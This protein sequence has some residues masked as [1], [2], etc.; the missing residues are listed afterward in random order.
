MDWGSAERNLKHHGSAIPPL[1]DLGTINTKA[2]RRGSEDEPCSQIALF[3]GD[4]DWLVAEED[5][6]RILEQ[7]LGIITSF[8]PSSSLPLPSLLSARP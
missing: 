6:E 8:I 1:Y 2:G 3:S 4:N 7:V 5:L